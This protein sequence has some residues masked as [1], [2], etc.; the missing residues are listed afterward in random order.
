MQPDTTPKPPKRT[1]FKAMGLTI[2]I[3]AI[4]AVVMFIGFNAYYATLTH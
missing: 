1:R 2:A 3:I 4:L